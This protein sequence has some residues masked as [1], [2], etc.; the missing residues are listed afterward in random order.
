LCRSHSAGCAEVIIKDASEYLR[1]HLFERWTG[2]QLDLPVAMFN[3]VIIP[4]EVI[5]YEEFE[6]D[7]RKV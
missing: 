1:A 3:A 4:S 6:G 2:E 7:S 5:I